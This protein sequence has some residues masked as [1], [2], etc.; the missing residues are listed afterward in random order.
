[1]KQ[2][3]FFNF[4]IML[5]STQCGRV[6]ERSNATDSKSVIRF[7]RIEG[8]NP[9]PSATVAFFV[10]IETS[11]NIRQWQKTADESGQVIDFKGSDV[12]FG[13]RAFLFCSSDIGQQRTKKEKD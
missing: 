12:Y 11:D 1:M 6:A 8:S 5:S 3:K 2:T 10:P 9:S 13:V 7:F 4:A